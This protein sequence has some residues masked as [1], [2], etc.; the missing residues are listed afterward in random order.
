[1]SQNS[2]DE[3]EVAPIAAPVT[4][5]GEGGSAGSEVGAGGT[6]AAS[7]LKGKKRPRIDLDA[8]IAEANRLAEI[9][10]KMMKSAKV[11]QQNS[12]RQKA[13]LLRK[14]GKLSAADL[15]RIAVLKR[16]GLYAPEE[17]QEVDLEERMRLKKEEMQEKVSAAAARGTTKSLTAITNVKGAEE[18][19]K[20]FVQK[21]Q[22]GS[23]SGSREPPSAKQ[24]VPKAKRLGP[25]S[26]TRNR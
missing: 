19:M 4:P 5:P 8:E 13:R 2:G 25:S 16:C 7:P 20:A 11:V 3:E 23:S 10:R 12:R 9:S 1:M 18:V 15:E 21:A 24:P 26:A 17:E 6:Q 22:S 14:A